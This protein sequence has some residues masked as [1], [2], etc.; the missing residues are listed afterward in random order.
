MGYRCPG[1]LGRDLKVKLQECP[2]CGYEVEMFSDELKVLCPNCRNPVYQETMPSCIDW[3]PA[4]KD[5]LGSEK[6]Q[7]LQE[8]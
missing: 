2:N 4:A 7:Q 5:C 8:E 3:C 6:W 1:Q